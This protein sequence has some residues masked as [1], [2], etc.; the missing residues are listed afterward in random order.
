MQHMKKKIFSILTCSIFQSFYSLRWWHFHEIWIMYSDIQNCTLVYFAKFAKCYVKIN[1][2]Y[3][4]FGCCNRKF[5]MTESLEYTAHCFWY[6]SSLSCIVWRIRDLQGCIPISRFSTS[7]KIWL[8]YKQLI[9]RFA[10]AVHAI[11]LSIKYYLRNVRVMSTFL[12]RLS[13]SGSYARLGE[14]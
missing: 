7:D 10:K 8:V 11:M 3:K 12:W 5:M 6:I 9:K 4:M 13:H 1:I 2:W 14:V